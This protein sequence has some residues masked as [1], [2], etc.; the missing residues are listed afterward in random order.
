MQIY[1]DPKYSNKFYVYLEDGSVKWARSL[2]AAKNYVS[3]IKFIDWYNRPI[4]CT[5]EEIVKAYDGKLY[6][7]SQCPKDPSEIKIYDNKT[8]FVT[9]VKKFIDEKLQ[10]LTKE[11][12]SESFYTLISWKDSKIEEFKELA[13]SFLDYRDEI[14]KYFL[15]FLEKYDNILS[16]TDELLD[17]SYIY[18]EFIEN[19]PKFKSE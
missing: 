4:Y 11:Y 17:L 13:I 6:L 8:L 15:N 16:K 18:D 12:G 14:Y 19:F 7:K 3:D 10:D 2:T 5:N 9:N 1:G